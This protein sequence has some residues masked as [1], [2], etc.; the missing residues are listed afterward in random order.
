MY[1]FVMVV[2]LWSWFALNVFEISHDA[3]F[4][5]LSLMYEKHLFAF[6]H[7]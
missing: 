4:I 3:L 1:D 2:F 7:E 6:K 5:D